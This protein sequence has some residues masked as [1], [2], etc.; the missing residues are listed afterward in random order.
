MRYKR[1]TTETIEVVC[2]YDPGMGVYQHPDVFG[3]GDEFRYLKGPSDC[4]PLQKGDWIARIVGNK[5]NTKRRV[6]EP[7][8]SCQI[9][10]VAEQDAWEEVEE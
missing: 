3:L 8:T 7:I 10:P 2:V 4:I 9:I 5:W 1:T 6:W